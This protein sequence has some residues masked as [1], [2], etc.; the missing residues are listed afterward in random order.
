MPQGPKMTWEQ[1]AKA[2]GD[3]KHLQ[4][5]LTAKGGPKTSAQL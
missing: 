1:L 4:A 2:G 3:A 5:A